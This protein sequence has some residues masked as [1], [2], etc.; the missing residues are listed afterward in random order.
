MLGLALEGG[1]AKGAF[2]MGAVKAL[3]EEG[4]Q[5]DGVVGTS[6]GA[7]NGAVIAQG[8]FELGYAWWEK[9]EMSM[10]YD[11][12]QD[13]IHKLMDGKIDGQAIRYL[14]NG[15]KEIIGNKGVDTTKMRHVFDDIIDEEKIRKSDLDFG[16][17]TVSIT[18][19][20]P[21][22][23]YKE[24]IPQGEMFDYLMASANFPAFRI[25][26][27]D[28]KYYVDGG[29]YDNCPINLLVR[30]GYKDIIAIRTLGAGIIRKVED[31]DVKITNI[32]PSEKLGNTLLFDKKSIQKNLKLGYCDAMR[33]LRSLQGE[34][35]Y[36]QNIIEPQALI[37]ALLRIPHNRL[38]AIG[39]S[40][41]LNQIDPHRM[42][43]EKI[44]PS[45][46]KR[47]KLSVVAN[48]QE[49]VISMFEQMAME[50]GIDRYKIYDFSEFITEIQQ[51][52]VPE[53]ISKS[54]TRSIIESFGQEVLRCLT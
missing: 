30:K 19:L 26:P 12:D 5:F 3:L 28:G 31:Q 40:M 32:F 34:K 6:I 25:E 50:R 13:E 1:G 16:I 29:F 45:I 49:I 20:K 7:L 33:V 47:R 38:V 41:K 22:E 48:Y 15:L 42:L 53:T 36:L 46:A 9:V 51:R 24:D 8:D 18:D 4:Y 23:L 35:Y 44:L 27:I 14:Y 2:H 39:D 21:L 17:V 10:L 43:F 54:S 52:S 37:S 11:I